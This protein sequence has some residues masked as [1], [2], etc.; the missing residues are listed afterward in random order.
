MSL[1]QTTP[2]T[3]NSVTL[4]GGPHIWEPVCYT[5]T[6]VKSSRE[7]FNIENKLL[8]LLGKFRRIPT[9]LFNTILCSQ[10][11]DQIMRHDNKY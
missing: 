1:I 3:T 9:E 10:F 5:Q 11:V 7:E 2:Q 4:G 6:Q 8:P